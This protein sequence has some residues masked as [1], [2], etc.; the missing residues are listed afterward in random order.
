MRKLVLAALIAP[1]LAGCETFEESYLVEQDVIIDGQGVRV[2]SDLEEDMPGSRWWQF[3]AFNS[4]DFP[5][6]VQ[7]TLDQNSQTSGHS[8]GAVHRIEAFGS[9]D[10][11]Y[12]TAPASF[13]V[14]AAVFPTDDDG[15]CS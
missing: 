4:N 15:A 5:A 14:N 1:L 2:V 13:N 11:G 10:V 3:R 7:V 8:M 9:A 6:C 12:I